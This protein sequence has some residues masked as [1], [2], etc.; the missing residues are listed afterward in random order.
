MKQKT[1]K[2][3]VVR[4]FSCLQRGL[5]LSLGTPNLVSFVLKE[6]QVFTHHHIRDSVTGG[7]MVP[8]AFS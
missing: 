5:M 2:I 1:S 7:A 3:K 4:E 8:G 6:E